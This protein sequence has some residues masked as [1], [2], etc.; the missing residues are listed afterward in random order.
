MKAFGQLDSSPEA[1][2]VTPLQETPAYM[3]QYVHA[4]CIHRRYT[5]WY[6]V[7]GR[8]EAYSSMG[9]PSDSTLEAQRCC[10]P[11]DTWHG[12]DISPAVR[13]YYIICN[14]NTVGLTNNSKASRCRSLPKGG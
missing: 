14:Y 8:K 12:I 5:P 2:I 13:I 11:D 10:L 3:H 6:G 4:A 1:G 7:V 9:S